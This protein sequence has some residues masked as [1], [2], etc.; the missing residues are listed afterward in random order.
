[1]ETVDQ[2]WDS[3]KAPIVNN[4]KIN[5]IRD[6][7]SEII[8]HFDPQIAVLVRQY[9]RKLPLHVALSEKDDLKTV[10]QLELLESLKVW[11]PEQ[12]DNLWVLARQRVLGAM[13][14]HIRYI[15][16]SDPS[17]YYEWVTDAAYIMLEVNNR[18][19]FHHQLETGDQLNRAMAVLSYRERKIVVAHTKDDMTFKKIGELIGVSESQV[20]R[21]YKK[22]IDKIKSNL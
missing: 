12:S 9:T 18:A 15:S 6:F 19:D 13:K 20:S 7:A 22:A 1:M 21:I 8:Q 10:A 4:I 3:I 5:L 16:K 2:I 11:D 17:R 14:D